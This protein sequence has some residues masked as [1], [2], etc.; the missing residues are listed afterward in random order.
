MNANLLTLELSEEKISKV[1]IHTQKDM[2]YPEVVF[3]EVVH[4]L[5]KTAS[6]STGASLFRHQKEA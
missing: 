2:E 6:L 4:Y 3:Y 1:L 5:K